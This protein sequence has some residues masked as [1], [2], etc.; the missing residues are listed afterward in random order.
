MASVGPVSYTHLHEGG[1]QPGAHDDARNGDD[2]GEL[3]R[4]QTH[5]HRTEPVSYTHLDVYKRQSLM[6]YV[7][8][9]P[10]PT[11]ASP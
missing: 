11:M 9:E 4:R 2:L 10:V 5:A 6:E 1:V 8:P 7:R 3:A